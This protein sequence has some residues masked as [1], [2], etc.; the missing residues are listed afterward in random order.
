MIGRNP[1]FVAQHGHG[2]LT[3]LSVYAAWICRA[4]GDR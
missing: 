2:I 1:F 3:M 4:M